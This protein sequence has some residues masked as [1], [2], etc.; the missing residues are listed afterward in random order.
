M[1]KKKRDLKGELLDPENLEGNRNKQPHVCALEMKKDC[2]K[3]LGFSLSRKGP[4]VGATLCK[5]VTECPV[6]YG[7]ARKVTA[8]GTILCRNPSPPRI[9][10]IING[11]NIPARYYSAQLKGFT[12][13]TGNGSE[14]MQQLNRWLDTFS[15]SDSQK[16]LIL[17]GPVGV[18][19]TYLLAALGKEL[20]YR[21]IEV[22][23][24]D[25]FQL[26]NKL[27][28][29][30]AASK[31]EE[32]P[33]EPLINVDVLF[34]DELGKGRSTDFELSI[35]D[36]LVMGRYNQN[37]TI[38]A[39]TNFRARPDLRG[40][41]SLPNPQAFDHMSNNRSSFSLDQ[42][43]SLCNRVGDRIYSRLM[44]TTIVMEMTG[45]DFRMAAHKKAPATSTN[46]P[47]RRPTS[48]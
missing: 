32:D 12:N 37:K 18:G 13:N 16:G 48:S 4:I 35:I 42:N 5:C 40:G 6:C 44:E 29:Y 34:I 38:V 17:E 33:L 3:G 15:L 24:I 46:S 28:T 30:Y 27:K 43:E 10:N 9:V 47:G 26:L 19:K 36:Q 1:V 14:V 2:C 21:G 45:E 25:F 22:K 20:A 11:A 41:R 7:Q 31:M 8:K 23:F 39:S